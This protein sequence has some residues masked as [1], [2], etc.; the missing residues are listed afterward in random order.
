MF[1]LYIDIKFVGGIECFKN[2]LCNFFSFFKKFKYEFIYNSDIFMYSVVENLGKLVNGV[3]N[4][5]KNE[6]KLLLVD[7]R[8]M[9]G[10]NNELLELIIELLG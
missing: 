6:V 3:V 9:L 7:I 5:E 8:I 2:K 4:L 1:F 10:F